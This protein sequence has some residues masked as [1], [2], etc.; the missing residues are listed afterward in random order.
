MFYED[1]INLISMTDEDTIKNNK[2]II[3][4][5]LMNRDVVFLIKMLAGQI[6]AYIKKFFYQHLFMIKV[7]ESLG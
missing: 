2:K 4:K 1:G 7:M 3:D 6:E 5:T